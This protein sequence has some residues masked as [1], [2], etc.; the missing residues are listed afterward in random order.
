[1]KEGFSED[2]LGLGAKTSV[3]APEKASEE[4]S[5]KGIPSDET[6]ADLMDSFLAHSPMKL[7]TMSK[8]LVMFQDAGVNVTH[9]GLIACTSRFKERFRF[10]PSGNDAIIQSTG[11]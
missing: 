1:M 4:T 9:T 10:Y 7:L 2:L 3:S 8:L 11:R 5:P 6:V